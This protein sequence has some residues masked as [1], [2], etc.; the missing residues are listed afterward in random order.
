MSDHIERIN[1]SYAHTEIGS[2]CTRILHL[3]SLALRRLQF[4]RHDQLLLSCLR[5]ILVDLRTRA[6]QSIDLMQEVASF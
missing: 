5:L 3:M 1:A 4:F 2:M 6:N